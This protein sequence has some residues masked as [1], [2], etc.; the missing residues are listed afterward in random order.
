MRFPVEKTNRTIKRILNASV[1]EGWPR[2]P[3]GRE[4]LVE[5]V[6]PSWLFSRDPSPGRRDPYAEDAFFLVSPDGSYRDMS[7]E[8]AQLNT[9]GPYG[10]YTPFIHP[11]DRLVVVAPRYP[12]SAA[13]RSVTIYVP[14]LDHAQM[15]VAR[16]ALLVGDKQ[17]IETALRPFDAYAGIARAILERQTSTFK[18]A[19]NPKKSTKQIR[20]EVDDFLRA[21]GRL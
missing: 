14:Q 7:E 19:A 11:T 15:D 16:D 4:V 6:D 5:E 12:R 21:Q 9:T 10:P 20:R 17:L 2:A 1:G 3:K 13:K 8:A 18:K